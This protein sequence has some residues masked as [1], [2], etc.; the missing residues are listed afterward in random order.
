MR[1][2][3]WRGQCTWNVDAGSSEGAPAESQPAT[4]TQLQVFDL[5]IISDKLFSTAETFLL[6]KHVLSKKLTPSLDKSQQTQTLR[7]WGN[8]SGSVHDVFIGG[9]YSISCLCL[10][11][12]NHEQVFPRNTATPALERNRPLLISILQK[13]DS[14]SCWWCQPRLYHPR[15]QACIC[16][17]SKTH[18]IYKSGEKTHKASLK[19]RKNLNLYWSLHMRLLWE[20][21]MLTY[22]SL[23]GISRRSRSLKCHSLCKSWQDLFVFV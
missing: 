23:S 14:T 19:L 17:L 2:H 8:T 5:L 22:I 11:W 7:N 9:R 3:N 6:M 21:G 10:A 12:R 1:W 18:K 15:S 4:S 20:S 13:T 16:K